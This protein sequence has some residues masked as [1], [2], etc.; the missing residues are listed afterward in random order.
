MDGST[1]LPNPH[2][3]VVFKPVS[4][5]GVLL[6]T[7]TEIYFGL[8][9][10]GVVVW[11]CLAPECSNLEELCER[12][13]ATYPEVAAETIRTDARELLASLEEKKLVVR[14]V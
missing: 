8:N 7:E 10:V 13:Q 6:H 4:T 5:G 1:A 12:L 3:A 14:E 2:P 9:E 11:Q